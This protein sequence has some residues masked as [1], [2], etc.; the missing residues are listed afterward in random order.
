MAYIAGVARQFITV[1]ET[2]LFIRQAGSVWD[3]HEREAFIEFIAQNPE[4][5]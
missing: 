4:E 5:S 3:E 1:A 2:P